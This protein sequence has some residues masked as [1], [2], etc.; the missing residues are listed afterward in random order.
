MRTK[1]RDNIKDNHNVKFL[2]AYM[3]KIKTIAKSKTSAINK[4]VLLI[5][6]TIDRIKSYINV[7]RIYVLQYAN[8]RQIVVHKKRS[9]F[10]GNIKKIQSKWKVRN[11]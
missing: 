4:I 8:I 6:P 5:K 11:S 2:L 1:C 7:R 10:S 3:R 9:M